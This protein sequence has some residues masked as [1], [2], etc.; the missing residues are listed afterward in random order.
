M[1]L[2]FPSH[3]ALKAPF[4]MEVTSHLVSVNYNNE[5]FYFVYKQ[6]IA[7]HTNTSNYNTN[8]TFQVSFFFICNKH[9][10]VSCNDKGKSFIKSR[11]NKGPQIDH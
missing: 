8:F 9:T 10:W 3:D 2:T 5:V 4:T 1:S 7:E 6:C 11:N